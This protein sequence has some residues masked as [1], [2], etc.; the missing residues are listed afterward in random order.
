MSSIQ[1]IN[2]YPLYKPDLIVMSNIKYDKLRSQSDIGI[3]MKYCSVLQPKNR[4]NGMDKDRL[5]GMDK[6]GLICHWMNM[7]WV[8]DALYLS[9]KI[10]CK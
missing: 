8:V 3:W 5:S 7:V 4:L 6:K 10:R 1:A 9:E 2:E